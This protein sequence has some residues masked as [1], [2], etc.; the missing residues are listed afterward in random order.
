MSSGSATLSKVPSIFLRRVNAGRMS[1]QNGSIL[2]NGWTIC[3]STMICQ[4]E[5]VNHPTACYHVN[6]GNRF[7]GD[8]A[9]GAWVTR[10]G[11]A[12]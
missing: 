8:P 10:F 11:Y 9:L 2:R 12:Q 7:G 4:V 5:S 1:R 3:A 6:T